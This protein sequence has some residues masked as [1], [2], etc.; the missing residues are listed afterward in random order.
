MVEWEQLGE[1]VEQ[2]PLD[3]FEHGLSFATRVAGT[4]GTGLLGIAGG[5]LATSAIGL[6]GGPA[7]VA[8]ALGALGGGYIGSCLAGPADEAFGK[9]GEFLAQKT[10]LS[11]PWARIGTRLAGVVA[12]GAVG[13]VRLPASAL[14]ALAGA[15]VH[16]LFGESQLALV[17]TRPPASDVTEM[18]FE[19]DGVYLGDQWLEVD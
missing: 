6:S 5:L 8:V 11:K 4:V 16:G 14:L 9:A 19:E 17:P 18:E 7:L 3:R 12:L 15:T 13:G 1:W 10:G 2:S